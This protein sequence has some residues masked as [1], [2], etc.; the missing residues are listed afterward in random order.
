[1]SCDLWW[2]AAIIRFDEHF[3]K[4]S[5][6]RGRKSEKIVFFGMVIRKWDLRWRERATH[7]ERWVLFMFHQI[8]FLSHL[9]SQLFFLEK[10]KNKKTTKKMWGRRRRRSILYIFYWVRHSTNKRTHVGACFIFLFCLSPVTLH[11]WKD[12][13]E[14]KSDGAGFVKV[15]F[16]KC[17][18]KCRRTKASLKSLR[19][20]VGY[21]KLLRTKNNIQTSQ[22]E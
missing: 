7:H 22:L 2:C 10:G 12:H 17:R 15:F 4:Y 19:R 3:F 1:M 18:K 14:K 8:R 6:K 5:N 9:F 13:Q 21:L 16:Y 11:S 20:F